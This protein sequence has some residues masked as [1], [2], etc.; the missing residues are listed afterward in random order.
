MPYVKKIKDVQKRP[1]VIATLSGITKNKTAR[2][3][4][5]HVQRPSVV[6]IESGGTE[7]VVSRAVQ[8]RQLAQ[9]VSSSSTVMCGHGFKGGFQNDVRRV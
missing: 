9:D 5:Y 1:V 6:Q 2:T 8:S 3:R 4:Q 7:R